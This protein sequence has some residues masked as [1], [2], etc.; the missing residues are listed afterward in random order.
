[1]SDTVTVRV[2]ASEDLPTIAALRRE[3]R[4]ETEGPIDDADY[5][6]RFA[7]WAVAE[8]DRRTFFLVAVDGVDAGMANVLRYDRMP[9]PGRAG[10]A[11]G[12]VGNVFVRPTHRN[13]GVGGVLMRAVHDWARAAGYD[14]LRLAPRTESIPFYERLGYAFG[15][16]MEVDP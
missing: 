8:G 3:W 6:R 10:G 15:R 4:E 7:D 5:E 9:T 16:V 13:A 2:A 14:H 11:W 1:L 12:Y